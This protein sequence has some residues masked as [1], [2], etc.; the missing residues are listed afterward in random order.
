[1][2]SVSQIDPA[3]IR[4]VFL[5]GGWKLMERTYGLGNSK[6]MQLLAAAGGKDLL[7]ER[8]AVQRTGRKAGGRQ[9]SPVPTDA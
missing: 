9:V 2:T 1:M 4:E 5:K 6:L 8:R 3:E 7:A